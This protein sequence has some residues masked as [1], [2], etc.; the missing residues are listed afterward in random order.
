L[1]DLSVER[2]GE[3]DDIVGAK[4]VMVMSFAGV[5]VVPMP[6]IYYHESRR[7]TIG[8]NTIRSTRADLMISS[9]PAIFKCPE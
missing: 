4:Q 8:T 3:A 2:E 7:L 1:H 6:G 5:T 9:I